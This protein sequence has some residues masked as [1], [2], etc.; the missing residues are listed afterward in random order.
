MEKKKDGQLH[1]GH[2]QRM[3]ERF[4][5][6]DGSENSGFQKHELLEMLLFFSITR[7][8]TNETAH[9]LIAT[10]GSLR[11]VFEAPYDALKS[12]PGVGASSAFLIRLVSTVIRSYICETSHD[13]VL[14]LQ[15]TADAIPYLHNLFFGYQHEMLY[16]LMF[17]QRGDLI[18]AKRVFA[19]TVN[20]TTIDE[21]RIVQD[22]IYGN[23]SYV[24]LAHN[25]PSGNAAYSD[26]DLV[27]T[28]QMEH[29]FH[30]VGICLL[31]HYIVTDTSCTGIIGEINKHAATAA[32]ES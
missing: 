11:G 17:N 30:A 10:F 23:A 4:L 8:N 24:I 3:R 15:K 27:V 14:Q 7:A 31:E 28:K 5:A 29:A 13:S 21:F 32:V 26:E 20:R 2:R 12:V 6:T 9:R 19:G 25:H 22:A 18:S 16:L 1:E